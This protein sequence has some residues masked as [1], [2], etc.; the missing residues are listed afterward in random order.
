M[1]LECDESWG[2]DG[3]IVTVL[4]L[5]FRAANFE[6]SGWESGVWSSGSTQAS[7]QMA[8]YQCNNVS[9]Q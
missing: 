2:G 9:G 6:L 5:W 7:Q 8:V 4:L 3:S 1:Q